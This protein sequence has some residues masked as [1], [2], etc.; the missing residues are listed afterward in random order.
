MVRS[1]SVA[2]LLVGVLAA[3]AGAQEAPADPDGD[4]TPREGPGPEPEGERAPSGGSDI[5]P[6][7]EDE[8]APAGESDI[9]REGAPAPSGEPGSD[10]EGEPTPE[11]VRSVV[12]VDAAAYGID[13]VVG[14][15]VT[16]RIRATA[17]ELGYRVLPREA[18]VAAAGEVGMTYPPSPAELWRVTYA[19]RADRGIFARV[20]ADHGQYVT[21]IMVASLDGT[22]PFFARGTSDSADLHS[23]VAGLTRQALP[24]PAAWN[25]EQAARWSGRD[26]RTS[27]PERDDAGER[28]EPEG[29][30]PASG[31]TGA[32][33]SESFY[34]ERPKAREP[35]PEE[36]GPA[37]RFELAL[38]TEG[39]VGTSS[40][41]FYNH[42]LGVRLGYRFTEDVILGA[43]VA[44]ANLN[45][46]NERVSNV[47]SYLQVEHRVQ[48][49]RRIG[50]SIPLRFAIGYLP[51]NGPMVRVGAGLNLPLSDRVEVGADLLVPT[52]WVLPDRTAVSFNVALELIVRL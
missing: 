22:G 8:R 14:R 12:V 10:P 49:A 38:Q 52:F 18:S 45:G 39:A 46:R 40:N 29:S 35:E 19:A 23:V 26:G 33:L 17:R 27:G 21:E 6:E 51:Y 25:A 16:R 13:P 3:G 47:L 31:E 4:R 43:Y 32:A 48:I 34:D 41:G 24:P 9:E 5:A 2:C 20:W 44:Y 42:L 50:L 7:R 30:A 37:H 28:P 36:E 1:A 15:H 11:A